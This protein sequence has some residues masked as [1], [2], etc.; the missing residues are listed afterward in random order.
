MMKKPIKNDFSKKMIQ[1]KMMI[2]TKKRRKSF[3]RFSD[4]K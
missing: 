2:A 3:Q 1:L 4:G